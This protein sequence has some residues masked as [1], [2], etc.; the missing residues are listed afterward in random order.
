MINWLSEWRKTRASLTKFIH[1]IDKIVQISQLKEWKKKLFLRLFLQKNTLRASLLHK[2]SFPSFSAYWVRTVW[3]VPKWSSKHRSRGIYVASFLGVS[4]S[5]LDSFLF[6]SF[7]HFILFLF[8]E[9][10][11]IKRT[12]LFMKIRCK[13]YRDLPW[14]LYSL[15]VRWQLS[16]CDDAWRCRPSP[17]SCA[18]GR[19]QCWR[20]W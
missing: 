16:W 13:I 20:A 14:G 4:P 9:Y 3:M 11:R 2:T 12:E 19:T 1:L 18:A 15:L 6:F 10:Y 5:F 7:L 17:S 8:W